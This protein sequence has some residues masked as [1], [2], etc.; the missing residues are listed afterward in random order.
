MF[1]TTKPKEKVAPRGSC[2]ESRVIKCLPAELL[3]PLEGLGRSE[4][5]KRASGVLAPEA[6]QQFS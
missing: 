3:L 4:Q 5:S 2:E 6:S 1:S